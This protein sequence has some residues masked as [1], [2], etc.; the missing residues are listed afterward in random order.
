MDS[1]HELCMK[2]APWMSFSMKHRCQS[3]LSIS[4]H[5]LCLTIT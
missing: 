1:A 3:L 2:N 4:K 5:E